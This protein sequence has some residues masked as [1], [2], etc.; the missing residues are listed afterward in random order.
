MTLYGED[1]EQSKFEN[2][3]VYSVNGHMFIGG[4]YVLITRATVQQAPENVLRLTWLLLYYC[5]W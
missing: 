1:V 3:R 2:G 5:S 4:D